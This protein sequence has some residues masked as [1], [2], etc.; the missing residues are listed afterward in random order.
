MDSFQNCKSLVM[1]DE[2]NSLQLIGV[3]LAFEFNN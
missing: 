2:M 3:E 1:I